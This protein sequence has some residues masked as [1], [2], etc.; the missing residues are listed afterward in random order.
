[1]MTSLI[2]NGQLDISPLISAR[3]F[4]SK[5]VK[6]AESYLEIAGAIQAFEVTYEL[7]W[8]TLKKVLAFKGIEVTSA[9]DA[10]RLGAKE[11]LI[12]DPKVWFDYLRKRNITVH[13]YEDSIMEKVYPILPSFLQ[14]V[15]SLIS[16]L[17][18]LNEI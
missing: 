14:D 10:F 16:E 7:S 11:G 3:N 6:E 18:K 9:Y 5:A 13:E 4:L 2:L 8:K 17:E 12:N 15:N 1:M